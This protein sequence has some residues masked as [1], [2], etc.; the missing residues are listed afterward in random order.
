MRLKPLLTSLALGGILAGGFP[1]PGAAQEPEIEVRE[2]I[3]F[4]RPDGFA[5]RLDAYLPAADGPHPAVVLI[6]GGGWAKGSRNNPGTVEAATIMA[7]QG[8]ATFSVDY[9]LSGRAP[10][11]A[12]VE[13]VQAAV[14]WI[15]SRADEFGVDPS[16]VG[17][18]GHSAGGHLAAMLGTLGAGSLTTG[19]RVAAVVSWSGALDFQEMLRTEDDPEI[20]T[21]VRTFLDCLDSDCDPTAAQ[22]SPI[23]HVD[24]TDAP[25][26]MYNSS[27]EFVPVAQ[28]TA[29]AAALE[30]AGVPHQLIIIPGQQHGYL[31]YNSPR[32]SEG[33]AMEVSVRFLAEHLD[34]PPPDFSDAPWAG[35][36]PPQR[37]DRRSGEGAGETPGPTPVAT[38]GTVQ[39][40]GRSS[41]VRTVALLVGLAA[42]AAGG[43]VLG[44]GLVRRRRDR[45]PYYLPDSERQRGGVPEARPPTER[46]GQPS[47]RRGD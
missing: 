34:A 12:A 4:A 39:P 2:G 15:R 26:L 28:P 32:T 20:Q 25:M 47:G 30:A 35:A 22:A 43:V 29:M 1:A 31:R 44:I 13:D 23:N 27:D 46:L 3:V 37:S 10:Y 9:R 24:P 38:P 40:A 5:L 11:P 45:E 42:L 33:H 41:A 36:P 18:A 16:R 17:A 8:L 14:A 6:H 19:S 7:E 21:G